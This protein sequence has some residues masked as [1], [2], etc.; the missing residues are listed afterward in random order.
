MEDM[1]FM[2]IAGDLFSQMRLLC[3]GA[4][5]LFEDEIPSLRKISPDV[6]VRAAVNDI[7][8]ALYTLRTHVKT[9]QH[10]HYKYTLRPG[11]FVRP[12]TADEP[13]SLIDDEG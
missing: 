10:E 2:D 8:G 13:S 4:I 9:L 12:D 11:G 5:S 1:D 3:E 6:D 7:G